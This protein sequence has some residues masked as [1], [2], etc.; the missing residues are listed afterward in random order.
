MTTTLAFLSPASLGFQEIL[1]VILVI[2][3]LF[4]AKRIPEAAR[5]LGRAALEFK[6][7]KMQVEKEIADMA[8]DLKV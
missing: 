4:G 1:I 5:G 7:G 2:A 6:R 8:K 3:A